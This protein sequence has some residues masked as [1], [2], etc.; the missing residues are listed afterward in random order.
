MKLQL[1]LTSSRCGTPDNC[2]RR[3]WFVFTVTDNR[4]AVGI[5]IASLTF[6][7][8]NSNGVVPTPI[9]IGA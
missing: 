9:P 1:F 6:K 8:F 2:V 5:E 7:S 3:Y 4:G